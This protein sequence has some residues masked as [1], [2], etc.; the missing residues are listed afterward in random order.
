MDNEQL[1]K[2]GQA[3]IELMNEFCT[4][5]GLVYTS[6]CFVNGGCNSITYQTVEDE[7]TGCYSDIYRQEDVE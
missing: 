6:T 5:Y 1:Q 3:L 4:E 7:N 2:D